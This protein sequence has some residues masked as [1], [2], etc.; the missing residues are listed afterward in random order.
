MFQHIYSRIQSIAFQIFFTTTLLTS[1]CLGPRYYPPA[2]NMPWEWNAPQCAD[3]VSTCP[4]CFLWWK[5]L[6]DPI[7]DSLMERAALQNLD[8]YVAG[9]RIIEARM[10]IQGKQSELYPHIDGSIA[11]GQLSFNKDNLINDILCN[12]C[13]GRRR[14][15]FFEAGFDAEWE[16][17]LFG[18]TAHEIKTAQANA[19]AAEE[20]LLDI[21]VT[22][23]AEVARNY[24]ELRGLQQRE[25]LFTSNIHAQSTLIQLT[26]DLVQ[27]GFLSNFELTKAEEEL[28]LLEAQKLLITPAINRTIHRLSILLGYPPAELFCEL[29]S[30][31]LLPC[32]PNEKPIGVPSELLRRRPDIRKAEKN[33]E[34]STEQISSA[35]ASFFPRLSLTG[36]VGELSA[37]WKSLAS[38]SATTYFIAPNL[39]FPI[40]N[41]SMILQSIDL[42]K[43]QNQQALYLYQKT[44][45]EA[46]EEVENAL[47]TLYYEQQRICILKETTALERS[48]YGEIHDLYTRGI[49]NHRDLLEANRSLVMA[50]DAQIQGQVSLLTQ[51]IALYKALGGGWELDRTPGCD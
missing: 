16:I 10:A 37:N 39:L 35:I 31:R 43:I 38:K 17:D 50:E 1:C 49:K 30:P 12:S 2:C 41:S 46:L 4:D 19:A 29:S 3:Y 51:Y 9:T 7:L 24:V 21:W 27:I 48:L 45:L 40:F 5:A 42:S 14:I 20:S 33:L 22:L 32:L 15:N 25:K 34:A 23:S 6:N 26:R 18:R 47:T 36:F 8:L 11:A 13:P 44:V 28:H